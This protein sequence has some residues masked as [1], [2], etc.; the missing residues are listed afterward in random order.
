MAS[1]S[2]RNVAGFRDVEMGVSDLEEGRDWLL[3]ELSFIMPKQ[4]KVVA[5]KVVFVPL[6]LL[7]HQ[8]FSIEVG[9]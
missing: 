1:T 7:R 2:P 3:Q 4:A 9:N 5:P 8:P 6:T